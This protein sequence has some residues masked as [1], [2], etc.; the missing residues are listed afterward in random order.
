M[1]K[2]ARDLIVL[3]DDD[4]NLR[5]TLSEVLT[6]EGYQVTT[7][8]CGRAYRNEI[9]KN[10]FKIAVID[11]N[12]PDVSGF[13]LV[14]ETRKTSDTKIII[15]TAQDSVEDRLRGY[16]AGEH[17][18]LNKP[19]KA[20]ELLLAIKHLLQDDSPRHTEQNGEWFLDLSAWT[21]RAPNRTTIELTGKEI[22]FL[23]TIAEH[24][25]PMVDRASMLESLYPR[26]DLY[27]S[28]ALDAL[29]S[30]LKNKIHK[31]S[32]MPMPINV[33]YGEGFYRQQPIITHLP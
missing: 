18:Y 30:R 5:K 15:L 14:E 24:D 10:T 6:V 8:G 27:T 20:Q 9:A 23:K 31:S 26:S 25:A 28:R 12:L 29:V 7:V 22:K 3:V 13:D 19:I 33:V 21:L 11:I 1:T 32:G 16:R 2:G 17:L 4:D